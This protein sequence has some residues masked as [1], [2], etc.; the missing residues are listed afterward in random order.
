MRTFIVTIIIML[1]MAGVA[2]LFYVTGGPARIMALVTGDQPAPV[3]ATPVAA[4][5]TTPSPASATTPSP[6]SGDVVGIAEFDA[7]IEA[8]SKARAIALEAELDA[9]AKSAEDAAK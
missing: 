3:T 7:K 2:A 4:S 1:L 9:A 6:A 5:A 8:D